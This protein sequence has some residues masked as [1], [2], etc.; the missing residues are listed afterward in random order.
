MNFKKEVIEFDEQSTELRNDLKKQL[1]EIGFK[2][3][4][5]EIMTSESMR[6]NSKYLTFE[7]FFKIDE[8]LER[9]DF[10]MRM[11]DH[12]RSAIISSNGIVSD[13]HTCFSENSD[14]HELH[15]SINF[16]DEDTILEYIEANFGEFET[17]EFTTRDLY[18]ENGGK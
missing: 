17:L 3:D 6:S 5:F 12:N 16:L 18:F 7:L 14:L 1:I 10:E 4:Q 9:L 2:N 15:Q 13:G 8:Q 11:S